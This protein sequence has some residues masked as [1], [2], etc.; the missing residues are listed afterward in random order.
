[1]IF[2]CRKYICLEF[3]RYL[4]NQL[5]DQSNINSPCAASEVIIVSLSSLI[6]KMKIFVLN[7][8]EFVY[9]DLI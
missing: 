7:K 1:M 6:V 8:V 5:L 9:L 2:V 3:G 4:M